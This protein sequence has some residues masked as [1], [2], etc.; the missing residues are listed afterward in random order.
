VEKVFTI[1]LIEAWR[2]I[3]YQKFVE[4]TDKSCETF[5]KT[6]AFSAEKLCSH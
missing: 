1:L 3:F 4:R 6:A 2:E 5:I